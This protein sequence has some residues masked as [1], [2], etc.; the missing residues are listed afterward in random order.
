MR[1]CLAI[2]LIA[3]LAFVLVG[4]GSSKGGGS[5]VSSASSSGVEA[6]SAENSASTDHS[7]QVQPPLSRKD[8]SGRN[9]DRVSRTSSLRRKAIS[10]LV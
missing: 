8:V 6:S 7:G 3:V 4:C 5:S 1:K 2:V 10:K 9:F